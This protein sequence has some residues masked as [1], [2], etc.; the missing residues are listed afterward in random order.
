ME[1]LQWRFG[2]LFE[3]RLSLLFTT[4]LGMSREDCRTMLLGMSINSNCQVL[5]INHVI[6]EVRKL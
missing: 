6:T 5:R 3:L 4:K 1:H 2:F